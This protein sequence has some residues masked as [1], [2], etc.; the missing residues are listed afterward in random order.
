MHAV[1]YWL[2]KNKKTFL[3]A[4]VFLGPLTRQQIE[5][6]AT[7]HWMT[8]LSKYSLKKT[9]PFLASQKEQGLER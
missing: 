4:S 6:L 7:F 2:H 1:P 9:P 8:Q 3:M 5:I